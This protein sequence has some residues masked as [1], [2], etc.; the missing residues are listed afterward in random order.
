MTHLYDEKFSAEPP[1]PP[2]PRRNWIPACLLGCLVASLVTL[3]LCA[4]VAWYVVSN[5]KTLATK[6][7]RE[8]IV[9]AVQQS[10]LDD[11]EKQAII[12]QVD[13]VVEQY[14]AGHITLEDLGRIMEELAE[15]PLMGAI[16]IRSIETKYLAPSGLSDEEKAAARLTLGRV[17]RGVY[18]ERIAPDDLNA[19]LDYVT[20]STP[21]GQRELKSVVSDEDL[22]GLLAECKRL[23][24][25]A[26]VPDEPYEVRISE[27]FRRA[28]DRALGADE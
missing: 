21:D 15:S 13:R 23:A 28:I 1:L 27:E 8:A 24:D 11:E 6:F 16:M 25:E 9:G 19:A 2:E 10:E 12:A 20:V 22:R 4:G 14:Q 3:V 7:A 18:E 5:V 17:L 26:E